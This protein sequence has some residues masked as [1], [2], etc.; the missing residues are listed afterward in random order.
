MDDPEFFRSRAE[1]IAE[2]I[3]P[4][5]SFIREY[6]PADYV[7]EPMVQLGC[8]VTMTAP[9]GAGK[10]AWAII[11]AL[12]VA[13]GRADILNCQLEKGRVIFIALENPA[14]TRMRLMSA[15]AEFG[16]DP[17]G[18]G[19]DLC[20]MERRGSAKALCDWA[21]MAAEAGPI[22]LVIID[23]LA[24]AFDGEDL[25]HPTQAGNFVRGLRPITQVAGRPAV[26]ILAHPRK[27][28][29]KTELI[30]HG[31]GATLNEVDANLC[32]WRDSKTGLVEL[33]WQGKFRG[34]EFEPT[35]YRY[36]NT[37]GP[38]VLNAQGLPVPLTT[39]R[40]Y[41]MQAAPPVS[42][43]SAKYPDDIVRV[44]VRAMTDDPSG[45]QAQWGSA[46]GRTKSSVNDLLGK[47]HDRHW[48]VRS[49]ARWIV[50]AEG[51]SA[52]R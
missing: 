40:P 14:G 34:P 20:V 45:T 31:A 29:A 5:G 4:L 33:H 36:A 32:L 2:H 18:I 35:F 43:V 39:L 52:V 24:A 46:I 16:I 50:T 17:D 11:T 3:K 12:A 38:A 6:E 37:T 26:L 47:A 28:A 22:R 23:T 30:P 13:T 25:N 27:E 9:T 7:V 49:G 15:C 42:A 10:T 44:L 1:R 48:V 21:L 19:F 8:L 41:E 51:A